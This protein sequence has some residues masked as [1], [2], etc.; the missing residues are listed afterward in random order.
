M[1]SLSTASTPRTLPRSTVWRAGSRVARINFGTIHEFDVEHSKMIGADGGP[2][3]RTLSSRRMTYADYQRAL[4]ATDIAGM[5]DQMTPMMASMMAMESAMEKLQ[6][7]VTD[8]EDARS[9]WE[10]NNRPKPQ[11]PLPVVA[12]ILSIVAILVGGAALA[13]AGKAPA[14]NHKSMVDSKASAGDANPVDIKIEDN[15]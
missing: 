7:K 13:K 6:Q 11:G 10:Y 1:A 15:G 3:D 14:A 9:V 4:F 2:G 12:L 8:L 5:Q